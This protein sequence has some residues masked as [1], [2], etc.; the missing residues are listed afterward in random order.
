MEGKIDTCI[1]ATIIR[2]QNTAQSTL[3]FGI[4]DSSGQSGIH[5][6]SKRE[7]FN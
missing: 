2:F 6:Y 5:F 3:S 4:K 1:Q 7:P